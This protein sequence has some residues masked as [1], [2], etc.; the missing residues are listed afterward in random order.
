M[1]EELKPCP[2]C[3]GEAATK[4]T[5][6]GYGERY[7]AYCTKCYIGL[8]LFESE[9]DAIKAWN[10]RATDWI[11]VEER[12][13][14]ESGFYFVTADFGE[15]VSTANCHFDKKIEKWWATMYEVIAWMPLPEPYKNGL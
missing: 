1:S 13:P 14:E 4:S 3:G 7:E 9:E 12:L 15:Q 11:P 5:I 6:Y 10:K 2:F 8:D